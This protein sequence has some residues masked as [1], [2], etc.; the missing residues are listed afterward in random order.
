MNTQSNLIVIRPWTSNLHHGNSCYWIVY[1]ISSL[2]ELSFDL[3]IS[4]LMFLIKNY[5]TIDQVL[6]NMC[7]NND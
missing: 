6:H 7:F 5:I 3:F 4:M 1:S 2:I